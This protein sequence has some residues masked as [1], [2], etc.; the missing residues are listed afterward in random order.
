MAPYLCHPFSAFL[1]IL[2]CCGWG[3]VGRGW[4]KN[5]GQKDED[6]ADV[7][8]EGAERTFMAPYFCHP[9]SAF[10]RILL[11]CGWGIVGRVWQKN[12]GQKD[13]GCGCTV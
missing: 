2:L 10:L 1:R 8:C 13:E 4:Q 11:R 12:E 9:F 3:I 7:P 5:E 6:G